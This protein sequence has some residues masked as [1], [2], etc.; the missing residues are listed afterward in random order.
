MVSLGHLFKFFSTDFQT[1]RKVCHV[2]VAMPFQQQVCLKEVLGLQVF[3]ELSELLASFLLLNLKLTEL[4]GVSLV[5]L[6][7]EL[8]LHALVFLRSC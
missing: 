7:V 2:L 8:G 3:V 4:L 1:V 6:L 5:N